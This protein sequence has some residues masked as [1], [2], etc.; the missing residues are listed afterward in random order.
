MP[1]S[2]KTTRARYEPTRLVFA[3]LKTISFPFSFLIRTSGFAS[4][5]GVRPCCRT[6]IVTTH[7]VP[8][9][10]PA[11]GVELRPTVAMQPACATP[12][13]ASP[14]TAVDDEDGELLL[15]ANLLRFG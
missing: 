15:H 5:M 6:R 7:G 9:G 1:G 14:A 10:N 12:A 3:V 8:A 13:S 11:L 4:G 2:G